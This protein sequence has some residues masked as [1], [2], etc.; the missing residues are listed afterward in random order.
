VKMRKY[1]FVDHTGDLGIEIFGAGPAELFENA[2]EAFTEVITDAASVRVRESR[3]IV[4]EGDGMEDL[5]VRW[6]NELIFLFDTGGLLFSAYEIFSVDG[7]RLEASVHGEVYDEG[8][9]CIKTTVKQATY[10]NLEIVRKHGRWET[11]VIL[12]L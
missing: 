8:R 11:T 5:L 7:R 10:H 9:H 1:R 3:N 6:L 12:D 2:A 4:L